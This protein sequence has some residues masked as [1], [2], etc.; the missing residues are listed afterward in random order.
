MSLFGQKMEY[1]ESD[2]LSQIDG[3]LVT[4]GEQARVTLR[5]Q[6]SEQDKAR[7]KQALLERFMA[8]GRPGVYLWNSSDVQ[9]HFNGSDSTGW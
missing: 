5:K 3:F 7:G 6:L 8:D 1:R 2:T 4:D 9:A